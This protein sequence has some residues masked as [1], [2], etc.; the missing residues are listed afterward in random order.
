[1]LDEHAVLGPRVREL[2]DPA[3]RV[4]GGA[5]VGHEV[6][7]ATGGDDRRGDVS[8]A[9]EFHD[10]PI[11]VDLGHGHGTAARAAQAVVQRLHDL[12]GGVPDVVVKQADGLAGGLG[13]DSAVPEAVHDEE[14]G[15]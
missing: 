6:P 3:H 7:A 11:A 9:G 1:V 2:V 13:G 10:R 5:V 14:H 15:A 4:T 8:Q 12:A